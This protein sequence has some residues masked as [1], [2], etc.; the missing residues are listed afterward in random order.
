MEKEKIS[1]SFIRVDQK[2]K[3]KDF[4]LKEYGKDKKMVKGY[5]FK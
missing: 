1:Q 5:S 2:W 4:Y 3:E